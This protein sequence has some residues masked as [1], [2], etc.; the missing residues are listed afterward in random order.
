LLWDQVE[1]LLRT[2][3]WALAATEDLPAGS[4]HF[5][6][7]RRSLSDEVDKSIHGILRLLACLSS[8]RTVDDARHSLLH[9]SADQRAYA[10]EAI[11]QILPLTIRARVIALLEPIT[12][13]ERRKSLASYFPQ[14]SLPLEARLADILSANDRIGPWTATVT[15][16]AAAKSGIRLSFDSAVLAKRFDEDIF[17]ET[18]KWCEAQQMPKA[19]VAAE[20]TSS[21]GDRVG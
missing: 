1:A 17:H 12:I 7:L 20:T 3:A 18:L 19:R 8:K 16:F 4:A 5:S 2:A 11:E 21:L 13:E 6:P 10:L 15:L 9:G 14:P